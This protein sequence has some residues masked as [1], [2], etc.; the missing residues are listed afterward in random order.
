VIL[1]DILAMFFVVAAIAFIVMAYRFDRLG[2]CMLALEEKLQK[3]IKNKEELTALLKTALEKEQEL[4]G[5]L[6]IA[7]KKQGGP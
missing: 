1:D 5:L 7:I 4:Q 2:Q 3:S 6:D